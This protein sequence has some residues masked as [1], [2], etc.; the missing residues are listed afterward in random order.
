MSVQE[1]LAV[2][3]V[4]VSILMEAIVVVVNLDITAASANMVRNV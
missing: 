2:T 1:A 3:E 4:P